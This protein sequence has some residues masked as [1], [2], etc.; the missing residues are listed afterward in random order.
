M[1]YLCPETTSWPVQD[2]VRVCPRCGGFVLYFC[3]CNNQSL[4]D[5]RNDPKPMPCHHSRILFTN[6][7]CR[8]N[9]K[10]TAKSG[11]GIAY[12]SNTTGQLSIAITDMVDDF[13]VRSNQRVKLLAA[14]VGLKA[15]SS[16][17][18]TKNKKEQ[19]SR[20]V[21][22]DSAY[23]VKGITKWLRMWKRPTN[24][25]LFRKL[26]ILIKR[27]EAKN[28]KVR[29]WHVPREH[30]QLADRLAKAAAVDGT[31]ATTLG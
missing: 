20:I 10:P 2:L 24:L 16:T 6:S 28:I 26:D 17:F 8:N 14:I 18:T 25:D 13:A 31:V 15:L 4:H 22:S 12:S 30:N 23:V 27:L 11:I 19:R 29:F 5:L 21:A 3:A 1:L 9:G 7:A